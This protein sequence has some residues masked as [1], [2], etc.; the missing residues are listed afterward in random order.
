M[1]TPS[2]GGGA[3]RVVHRT[4][5]ALVQVHMPDLQVTRGCRRGLGV[6]TWNLQSTA[7]TTEYLAEPCSLD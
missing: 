7:L 6:H 1:S 5:N 2:A 4:S 3:P